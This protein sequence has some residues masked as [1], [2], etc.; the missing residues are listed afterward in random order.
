MSYTGVGNDTI[1]HLSTSMQP[2][3]HLMQNQFVDQSLKS[4]YQTWHYKN[5]VFIDAPTGTRKTTFV[6]D[7]LI[8]DAIKNNK[9]ILL[10]SN[11]IALR[12]QQKKR[13]ISIA[14]EHSNSM[15]DFRYELD[16]EDVASCSFFGPICVVTYQGLSNLLNST[17]IDPANLSPWF[18]NLKYAIFDEIHFLYSDA[19]FNTSCGYLLDYL[20]VVF[21]SAIRVY[22]TATSWDILESIGQAECFQRLR[23]EEIKLTPIEASIAKL[24]LWNREN[25]SPTRSFEYYYMNTNYDSYNLFF[26][27]KPL[28]FLNTDK[29]ISC[30]SDSRKS[31]RSLVSLMNPLPAQESKWVIFIDNKSIGRELQQ[32]LLRSGVSAAYIDAEK[33][34]P[35][36]AW[37]KLIQDEKFS[38]SVLIATSVL[39]CGI[40]ISDACVKNIAIFSTDRTAFMQLLG[41]KRLQQGEA[42]NL[43][44]WLPGK[45]YFREMERRIEHDLNWA[46]KLEEATKNRRAKPYL[47]TNIVR[48]IWDKRSEL[49][50]NATFYIDRT[51]SFAVNKYAVDILNQKLQFVQQFTRKDD[52][53]NFRDFVIEWLNKEKTMKQSYQETT[54]CLI[55]M[56][57]QAKKHPVGDSEISYLRNA[58]LLAATEQN[59]K[60]EHANRSN[61]F[62]PKTM[63]KL[64]FKLNIDYYITQKDKKWT[65]HKR[66]AD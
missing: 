56:L 32:I 49:S 33:Q 51:G 16:S 43:F 59:I 58:I 14:K 30:N 53:L 55:A 26:F 39:D 8:P 13:A 23:R 42:V 36:A 5:P 47:Y 61:R 29:P 54:L 63:N 48:T 24:N 15:A 1:E 57:D 45:A 25:Y 50:Y 22:M 18:A 4:E 27:D 64:L 35:K 65:A 41:R 40:N 6:Y 37:G 17:T 46:N 19:L 21:S 12:E 11:R 66:N 62:S 38:E 7:Y 44:V 20:P 52:P 10:V 31:L 3:P 34:I 60:I 9:T 28:S 2:K